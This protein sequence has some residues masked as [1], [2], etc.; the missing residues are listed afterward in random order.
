MGISSIFIYYYLKGFK[1]R[2]T[3]T[4]TDFHKKGVGLINRIQKTYNLITATFTASLSWC[5]DRWFYTILCT[6]AAKRGSTFVAFTL[7]NFDGECT[8]Y[9]KAVS[10]TVCFFHI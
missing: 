1:K 10:L 2:K 7:N 8:Q 9:T 6:Q 5:P 3:K 4:S